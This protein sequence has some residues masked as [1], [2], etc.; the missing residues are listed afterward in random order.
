M[1]TGDHFD[2][3]LSECNSVN[4]VLNTYVNYKFKVVF[5]G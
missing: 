2:K 3:D 5:R 1:Q 4:C